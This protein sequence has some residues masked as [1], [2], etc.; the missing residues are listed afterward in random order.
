MPIPA[1]RP[2][3]KPPVEP[4]PFPT[5]LEPEFAVEPEPD[6]EVVEFEEELPAPEEAPPA[7]DSILPG[8]LKFAAHKNWPLMTLFEPSI[9]WKI[10]Q[11]EVM[12]ALLCK[13]NA[14]SLSLS[15]GRVTLQCI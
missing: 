9:D 7:V 2:G 10:L 5:K 3:L 14:P 4:E 11:E 13:L 1:L 8:L 12:S 6:P 15:A